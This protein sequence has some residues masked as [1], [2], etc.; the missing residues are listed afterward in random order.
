MAALNRTYALSKANGPKEAIAEAEKLNLK[1]DHLYHTLLGTLY[2]DIDPLKS[3]NHL[4]E[5]LRLAKT[6]SDKILITAKLGK[7]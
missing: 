3:K 2:L 7:M 6:N 4:Q 1:N 5:A